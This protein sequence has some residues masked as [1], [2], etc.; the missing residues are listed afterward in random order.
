MALNLDKMIILW[1]YI[2][3]K[4]FGGKSMII[5]KKN[6]NG[7][8]YADETWAIK[9]GD[10]LVTGSANDVDSYGWLKVPDDVVAFGPSAYSGVKAIKA[11][12]SINGICV[13]GEQAFAGCRGLEIANLLA[14][15]GSTVRDRVIG[16]NAFAGCTSL[17]RLLI[18]DSF[19]VIDEGAFSQCESLEQVVLPDVLKIGD[20]AFAGCNKLQTF[21]IPDSVVEIGSEVFKGC[22]SLITVVI[23]QHLVEECEKN[24]TFKNCPR[25]QIIVRP[26]K[27]KEQQSVKTPEA[28]INENIKN[29][30]KF[31]ENKKAL[32]NQIKKNGVRLQSQNNKEALKDFE[33]T[34]KE[35]RKNF[36][37]TELASLIEEN[38]K[39]NKSIET[40]NLPNEI[41]KTRTDNIRTR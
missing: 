8:L 27:A 7:K 23:P 13:I 15:D 40:K 6:L 31:N 28:D 4:I 37:K 3:N 25:V 19:C 38:S 26:E 11:I 18:D 9:D 1:Y 32:K 24:G 10:V 2:Y 39:T 30:I 12:G 35:V 5:E 14:Q 16:A 34:E 21:E 36:D 22:K 33:N 20:R 17:K 29:A 41:K